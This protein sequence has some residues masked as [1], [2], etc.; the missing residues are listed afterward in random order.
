MICLKNTEERRFEMDY[1]HND[2]KLE[3]IGLLEIMRD[4]LITDL[5]NESDE[6]RN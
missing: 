3:L 1:M 4:N 5:R 2:G 6:K